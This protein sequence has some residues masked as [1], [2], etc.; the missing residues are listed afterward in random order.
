M[1]DLNNSYLI[2]KFYVSRKKYNIKYTSNKDWIKW[3]I[4]CNVATTTSLSGT[5]IRVGSR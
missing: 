3:D 5:G 4:F 1:R 2:K